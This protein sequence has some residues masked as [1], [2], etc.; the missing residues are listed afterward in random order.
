MGYQG[1]QKIDFD[2]RF[3]D[4]WYFNKKTDLTRTLAIFRG[5]IYGGI[6]C[7]PGE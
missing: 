2:K 7:G 4:F 1:L 6:G 5:D 3:K